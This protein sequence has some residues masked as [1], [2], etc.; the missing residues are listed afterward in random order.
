MEYNSP[1]IKK[2][3]LT[4]YVD[5]HSTVRH[6]FQGETGLVPMLLGAV[7]IAKEYLIHSI[8]T[9]QTRIMDT[10]TVAGI[11]EQQNTQERKVSRSDALAAYRYAL[12]VLSLRIK[13]IEKAP[14]DKGF[15]IDPDLLSRL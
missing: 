6:H 12:S 9:P 14:T 4:I 2:A 7:E 10:E 3:Q 15:V 13:E 11:D 5:S 8:K 1:E